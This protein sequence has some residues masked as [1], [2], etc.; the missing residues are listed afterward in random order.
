MENITKKKEERNQKI[1]IFHINGFI[2]TLT[3]IYYFMILWMIA[4]SSGRGSVR[5][6]SAIYL[7]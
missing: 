6:P 5:D 7:L 2:F 3:W 1:N 4:S